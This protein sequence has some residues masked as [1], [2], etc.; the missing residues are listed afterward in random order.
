MSCS[1]SEGLVNAAAM[2]VVTFMLFSASTSR[3]LSWSYTLDRSLTVMP[4]HG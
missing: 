1:G 4:Y 3:L 2:G